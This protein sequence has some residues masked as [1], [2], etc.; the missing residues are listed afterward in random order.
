[1]YFVVYIPPVIL[2]YDLSNEVRTWSPDPGVLNYTNSG[3][4]IPADHNNVFSFFAECPV[5]EK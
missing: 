3:R 1:M 2:F 5:V 4:C